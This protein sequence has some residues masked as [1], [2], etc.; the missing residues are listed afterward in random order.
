MKNLRRK[1]TKLWNRESK[2]Q[3]MRSDRR[4]RLSLERMEDRRLM[5]VIDLA[6]LTAQQGTVIT[7]PI[8]TYSTGRV[9][10]S[11]GDINGD[12]YDDLM[13][14][15]DTMEYQG[16]VFVV[17]GRDNMPSTID[18]ENLGTGGISFTGHN[19]YHGIGL[20]LSAA[21]DINGDG[22]DDLILGARNGLASYQNNNNKGESYLIFGASTLP[23]SI[24]LGSLGSKGVVFRSTTVFD[25]AGRVSAAGDVNGDGF[26]DLIIGAPSYGA[27]RVYFKQ[28]GYIV[29]GRPQFPTVV[30]VLDSDVIIE[31]E[32]DAFPD[33]TGFSVSS[34]GDVNGDGF[35]DLIL[36]APH[37]GAAGNLKT[38]AGS[39]F[40]IFSGSALPATIKL[41]TLGSLGV[42]IFGAD[43]GDESGRGVSNAGDV[44]GDGY[45]D[46]IIGAWKADAANNAKLNAGESYLIFGR[47]IFPATIDL[48]T[49]GSAGMTIFGAD[50][51]DSSGF[52]V[53][54]AGDVNA[55]GFD[56]LL[57]GA[58][59]ADALGNNKQSAGESYV[60]FGKAVLP[61]TM[62]LAQLAANGIKIIG[63]S[64]NDRSGQSVSDAGDV[65]GDGFTDL[66][67]GAT[68]VLPQSNYSSR[69][70]AGYV[71][72][73]GNGFTSSVNKLGT[74]VPETLTGTSA[75]D[76]M[77]G[78]RGD[79]ILIG[80]GG[81]DVLLG[82]QGND[83][84][85]FS[86]LD[87]RRID[88]GTGSDTL[89]F[90]GAD[91]GLKLNDP[92]LGVFETVDLTGTGN[93]L[94][95]VKIPDVLRAQN[96][97]LIVRGNAGDRINY[98]TGWSQA[99]NQIINGISYYVFTQGTA[100]LKV[101]VGI[102][103]NRAP[104]VSR[105]AGQVTARQNGPAVVLDSDATITDVIPQILQ[106]EISPSQS[107]ATQKFKI[108]SRS[109][110]QV[111]A[112]ARLASVAIRSGSATRL[113]V[114]LQARQP[115]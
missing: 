13:I 74:S 3:D 99:N 64:S 18:L 110:A 71:I 45:D 87:F 42:K 4:R 98:G 6:N 38:Y 11:A 69:S 54:G 26:D 93:N 103:V 73:G 96:D 67:I 40:L 49:L 112:L 15:A 81:A 9:V 1:L 51:D 85:A 62:N 77:V 68:G 61:S 115:W 59:G 50:A 34:A 33:L 14:A 52:S 79:D 41:A 91:L 16:R 65:N 39:S 66:I 10:S 28:G 82:G 22:F 55:D 97:T 29:Y 108:E 8:Y 95:V 83:V 100:T 94:L 80:N 57:I 23:T 46:L 107:W 60:I 56:D 5:A 27:S 53:S 111:T 19:I 105:F 70:G 109:L 90:D 25:A 20:S 44:N 35:D 24:E 75:A 30:S 17:F 106:G 101:Q 48:K 32:S 84:L 43:A 58:T 76:N 114:R 12:G 102:T 86:S 113:S 78:G 21:G 7:P 2:P 37:N 36:G 92:R 63:A 72:F 89:R 88:G 31:R 104:I 47:A